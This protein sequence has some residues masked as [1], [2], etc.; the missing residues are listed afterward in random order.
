MR[1]L[2]TLVSVLFIA[3]TLILFT[4]CKK[5][6]GTFYIDNSVNYYVDVNWNG[7]NMSANPFGSPSFT[8][9]AGGGYAT[10]YVEGYGYLDDVYVNVN[11]GDQGGVQVF[12]TKSTNTF[13]VKSKNPLKPDR[14]HK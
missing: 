2:I 1:K 3:M 5:P 4:G 12:Y 7:Y 11:A 9:D 10:I 6:Q 8:V 14:P 13:T